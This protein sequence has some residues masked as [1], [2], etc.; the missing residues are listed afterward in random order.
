MSAN[1]SLKKGVPKPQAEGRNTPPVAWTKD[2][3]SGVQLDQVREG[4]KTCITTEMKRSCHW[5]KSCG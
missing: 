5:N 2:K 4:W 3:R 1:V